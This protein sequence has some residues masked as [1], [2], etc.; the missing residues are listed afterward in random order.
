MLSNNISNYYNKEEK[1][2]EKVIEEKGPP[3]ALM[4]PI[5]LF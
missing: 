1:G 3:C 4:Y 5:F 2:F